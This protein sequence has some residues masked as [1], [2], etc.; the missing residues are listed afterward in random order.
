MGAGVGSLIAA[1]GWLE[2]YSRYDW[3]EQGGP[4]IA[5]CAIMGAAIGAFVNQRSSKS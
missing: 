4:P 1:Y 3:S 2:A 5:I